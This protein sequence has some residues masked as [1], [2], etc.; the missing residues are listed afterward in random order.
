MSP[1][2]DTASVG[3]VI[4]RLS[5]VGFAKVEQSG[6]FIPVA[7]ILLLTKKKNIKIVALKNIINLMFL[8]RNLLISILSAS[9]LLGCESL[10]ASFRTK[11]IVDR[12]YSHLY[13]G[14]KKYKKIKEIS[15]D[16]KALKYDDKYKFEDNLPSSQNNHQ[17]Y[18]K[19]GNPY[20]INGTTYVPQKYNYFE[21]TGEASWYG[22]D[23]HG[24]LTANGET[25]DMNSLTAAHR[26]M[27]MPSIAKVT[28][29]ENGKS[30][31]VRIN[32]RGPFAN[33]RIID[34]SKKSA[35][36]LDFKNKGITNIKVEYLKEETEK[37]L[38]TL[39]IK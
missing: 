24:K 15:Q 21:E 19:I 20:E 3:S 9:F 26:T 5:T 1:G 2:L 30:I 11:R 22:S 23:F 17:G 16:G 27:P 29:I 18:Y 38:Q 37:L 8:A 12:N 35:E 39:E 10:E 31:K 6:R 36:I 32:D 34:L 4:A 28:N 33:N 7:K 13:Y 14:H 25:Y